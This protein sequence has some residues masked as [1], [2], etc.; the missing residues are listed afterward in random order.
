[1][2]TEASECGEIVS[3]GLYVTDLRSSRASIEGVIP[4]IVRAVQATA[5]RFGK[6]R[7]LGR[8]PLGDELPRDGYDLVI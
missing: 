8:R 7:Y 2:E 1:M 5:A 4:N 6:V 3:L